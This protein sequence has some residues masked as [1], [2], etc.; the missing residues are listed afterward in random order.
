[1]CNECK[2]C[3]AIYSTLEQNST[4]KFTLCCSNGKIDLPITDNYP[5]E[6]RNLLNNQTDESKHFLN[7][8]RSYNSAL[9]FASVGAKVDS[10]PG[11]GPFCYRIHGQI[12]H[13]VGDL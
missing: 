9:A 3:K 11:R 4:G 2:F 12:Y 1:M 8:I 7:N 10:L 5:E 13:K 6:I